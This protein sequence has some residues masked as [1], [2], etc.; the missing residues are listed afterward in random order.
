MTAQLMRAVVYLAP[1]RLELR[2]V[3]I[4]QPGPD[5]I[6]V[7]IRTA[8]T[9][10]TNVKTYRRGHPKI[11]PPA[12]F[13]HELGGDVVAV[14]AEVKKFKPGMRVVPHNSAPCGVCYACKHGQHSMCDNILFYSGA[15]AE[16]IVVPG[17]V[18]RLNTFEIPDHL[19]YG[20]AAAM[21]PLACVVHG[22]DVIQ[23]QPGESVAI[24]GAGGPIGLMHLQMALRRGASQVIAVDL[25]DNRLAVADQLGATRIVNAQREDPVHVIHDLT[26]GRGADVAIESAGA[27]AAWL[28]AIQS[29]R[30]GGRVLW[31]GGL[32]SGTTIELDTTWIHYGELTLHG[33]YHATP[34]DVYRAFRLITSGV[35]NTEIL[36]SGKLPLER[37]EDALKMMIEGQ[38]IKM[39]IVPDLAP[40]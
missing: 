29:V 23:I 11:T 25:K 3:P 32:A 40:S 10:G 14:G 4:P 21:E 16:Y 35:I 34:L 39:A 18:V 28:T 22:Q 30:K 9:C 26:E 2:Q 5:E 15:F 19:S 33:V 38:C 27:K 36:I 6:L 20:Q 24:I 17:P 8:L 12:L 1:G 31:F 7:R 13:G 37:V